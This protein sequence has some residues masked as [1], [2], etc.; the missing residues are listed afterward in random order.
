[1]NSLQAAI[2]ILRKEGSESDWGTYTSNCV[3][4]SNYNATKDVESEHYDQI[5]E[6]MS[7]ETD[8]CIVSVML[9]HFGANGPS[10]ILV[11]NKPPEC[12]QK[13]NCLE[14]RTWLHNQIDAIFDKYIS[15]CFS[16]L[17]KT[18]KS[19]E[20]LTQA[21]KGKTRLPCRSNDCGR[22]FVYPKC[23][24][25]H[26]KEVHGIITEDLMQLSTTINDE[27]SE[28]VHDDKKE[29]FVLNYGC[30]HISLDLLLRN[31]Q[32]AVKGDGERLIRTWKFLTYIFR[33]KG[34]NKYALAGLRLIASVEGLLT[35]CQAHR[36]TWNRFAGRKEGKSKS[37][38]HD[39]R[40]EQLNKIS[41]EEI[42]ALAFANINDETVKT[43]T[44]ATS[45][46]DEMQQQTKKDL[47]ISSRPEHHSNKESVK[48]FQTILEQI[49][50]KVKM[51]QSRNFCKS[52]T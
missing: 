37:T 18:K 34:H 35:P 14:K 12:L 33:L 41:K 44:G 32:D 7:I 15:D 49:H 24:I 26:E 21:K 4:I 2:S 42:R 5:R 39:L 10:D 19:I 46:I 52:I 6:F 25:N 17:S 13:A 23:R 30:L 29:D 36:L 16:S 43:A 48:I 20:L 31:A 47:G 50:H 38:S 45:A 11:L 9:N 28:K 40:V 27:E 51:F 22:S 1:M 8:A 3:L